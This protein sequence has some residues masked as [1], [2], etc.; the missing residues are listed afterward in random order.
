MIRTSAILVAATL[1]LTACAPRATTPQLGPDGQPLPVAYTI[2]AR[3]A[4]EIPVRVQ[5][6]IN[7][8]RAGQGLGPIAISPLLT[9]AAQGHAADMSRQNRA[10]HFGSDGS[11][12][13]DRV[14]R[15]GY[16]GPLIGQ[17]ISE[18]YET[19]VQTLQAWMN[20]RDTRDVIMSPAAR[21]MGFAWHQEQNGKLWWTLVVGG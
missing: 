3:D 19:E 15:A 4:Q 16:A 20:L 13:L 17:N 2:S 18:T 6:Q 9:T 8:L 7:T 1:A 14:R 10:W 12:P 11:S 5:G 21:E